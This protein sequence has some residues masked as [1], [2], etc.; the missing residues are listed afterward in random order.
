M[1]RWKEE[2]KVTIDMLY[3]SALA[4]EM[5]I[6]HFLDNTYCM[7]RQKVIKRNKIHIVD[8][9]TETNSYTRGM[10]QEEWNLHNSNTN[11][12]YW[13]DV[14][15]NKVPTRTL[16]NLCT[17]DGNTFPGKPPRV[18]KYGTDISPSTN[19]AIAGF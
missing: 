2:K 15:T 8:G 13:D 17:P 11:W 12:M 16:T 1:Q 9:K 7:W 4:A 6:N 10:E 3:N 14:K 5:V 18:L 19:D